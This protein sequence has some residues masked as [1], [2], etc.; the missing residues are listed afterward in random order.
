MAVN[1]ITATGEFDRSPEREKWETEKK[2]IVTDPEQLEYLI[3][4]NKPQVIEQI[5]LSRPSERANLRVRSITDVHGD[6]RYTSALK[7][8]AREVPNGLLRRETPTPISEAAFLFYQQSN[9]PRLRKVRIEPYEGVS[10]DWIEGY[11]HPIVEI[12]DIGLHA[13]AQLF[14]QEFSSVLEER[15]GDKS[16]DNE[17]IAHHLSGVETAPIPTL[18]VDEMASQIRGYHHYGVSPIVVTIDGRSGSGKTT[19]ARQLEE[20]LRY[21]KDQPGIRSLVLSVDNYHRGKAWL[22]AQNGGAQWKDWDAAV[23]YDT[24]GLAADVAR[25]RSGETIE[26]RFFSF[27]DQESR[28]KG[29]IQPAPVIIIEGIH[30]GS[31]DLEG[32]RHF[33]FAVE[34][35]LATSLERDLARLRES[36]RAN[37]SIGTPE[38]RLRY[39]MEY[40]EPAFRSIDRVDSEALR[41]RR[42]KLARYVISQRQKGEPIATRRSVGRTQAPQDSVDHR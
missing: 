9:A 4:F 3:Q 11:E 27:A 16:V 13:D 17:W 15:T 2:Y 31:R 28:Y 29:T 12:E 36:T 32:I 37:S 7:T 1:V 39:Q 35:P 40:A 18:S 8:E 30:A 42:A 19:V 22:E 26:N 23:V 10:I 20:A 5:Y 41:E 33:H 34:T 38:A 21:Q 25:L 24:A 14:L 6:T